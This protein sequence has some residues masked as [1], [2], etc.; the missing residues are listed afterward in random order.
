MPISK[1]VYKD[2]GPTSSKDYN[3]RVRQTTNE[4]LD[5][6]GRIVAAESEV[7]SV[8]LLSALES[9]T[10]GSKN[11][12]LSAQIEFANEE[13]DSAIESQTKKVCAVFDADNVLS[14][15]VN[16][17]PVEQPLAWES[18]TGVITLPYSSRVSKLGYADPN[19]DWVM[20]PAVKTAFTVSKSNPNYSDPERAIDNTKATAF[21]V[22]ADA[23]DASPCTLTFY[24]SVPAD[25]AGSALVNYI[26]ID[27]APRAALELARICYT[28]KP[29]A[30][31][32][33]SDPSKWQD[34]WVNGDTTT[35]AKRRYRA[36]QANG[37]N[38]QQSVGT[39]RYYFGERSVTAV[40]V[41]LRS[42]ATI[43]IDESGAQHFVGIRNLDVGH[44]TFASSGK[45]VF[46]YSLPSGTKR[47]T[48]VVP[49][50]INS[51]VST[52]GFDGVGSDTPNVNV[53]TYVNSAWAQYSLDSLVPTG[54]DDIRLE[55][56]MDSASN[57]CT[58]LV[59]G[60]DVYYQRT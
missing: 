20:N 13:R 3:E 21:M 1:F 9:V 41:V 8:S 26:E 16:G 5:L 32:D 56:T 39:R 40:K 42:T 23:G 11:A 31:L 4:Y 14:T 49:R 57:G 52:D 18:D 15:N 19:G 33:E 6:L 38:V 24:V 51:G 2:R 22:R 60:F 10:I 45:R 59:T 58:P 47:I 17:T 44:V 7:S 34:L 35:A 29:G 30:T 37:D 36:P 28:T 25:A 27:P 12:A 50:L 53:Y 43:T 46:E 48:K 55:V 54:I